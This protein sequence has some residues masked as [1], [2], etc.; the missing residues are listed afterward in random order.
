MAKKQFKTE[1]KKLLDMMLEYDVRC[2]G[3][4]AAGAAV[5]DLF[6]IPAREKIGRAKFVDADNYV[7]EYAAIAE[8]MAQQIAAIREKAGADV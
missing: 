6:M 8:E 3:A 4:I 5:T 7:A 1:S 2:R